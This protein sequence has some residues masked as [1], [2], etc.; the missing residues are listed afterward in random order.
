MYLKSL[1]LQGFKSFP[2]KIKL[3]FNKGISA[4]VGPNGS[5]KSNIGD[6]MRWVMGEQSSKTLRGGKMEDV[7]FLGTKTRPKAGFAHVTLTIDNEDRSLNFDSDLVSVSRKLYR[8]GDSEYMINGANVRLKDVVELF[9]DTGLGRDGYSIIGQGRIADIVS[10]KSTERREI[11]EEAAGISKFRYKKA[12]AER[13]LAAAEDNIS[14]LNDILSELESRIGPLKKQSEKAKQ[15]KILDDDKS[16]LEISVW[17]FKLDKY[18]EELKGFED[19]LGELDKEYSQLSDELENLENDIEDLFSKSAEKSEQIDVL[20]EKI[21]GVELENS[22]SGAKIAVLENDINHLKDGILQLQEQIEQSRNSKY[23]LETELEKRKND[24]IILDNDSEKLEKEIT[25]KENEF[26]KFRTISD[27]YDKSLS[28]STG[29]INGLYLKKSEFSFKI[30]SAK[31]A[32]SDI[33]SSIKQTLDNK[34]ELESKERYIS[35]NLNDLRESKAKLEGNLSEHR[36][37]LSGYEKLYSSKADKLEKANQEFSKNDIKL[38]E[39][40][41]KLN[42][43]HDLENSMEGF[44]YSVKV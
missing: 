33:E 8:N 20:K 26:E 22:E 30:E 31:N 32:L 43:L 18:T 40:Q 10:S 35:K 12:E 41:Q 23:F 19:K 38:R 7:I 29:E 44:A 25:Q 11:F 34:T 1:E 27:E 28:D 21:H 6:A 24:L 9:M 3:D 4:V 15:F 13:K 42:L 36:N 39:N 17:V 16:K 2:D 14:R 37:R 5:G